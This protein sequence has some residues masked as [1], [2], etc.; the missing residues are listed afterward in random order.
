MPET[1]RMATFE[2]LSTAPPATTTTPPAPAKP[3]KKKVPK[4]EIPTFKKF[5]DLTT[6]HL[7]QLESEIEKLNQQIESLNGEEGVL[8][9][10]KWGGGEAGDEAVQN[11]KAELIAWVG[12]RLQ[13]Y[14]Q[15]LAAYK[16]LPSHASKAEQDHVAL[17]PPSKWTA[18]VA[19]LKPDFSDVFPTDDNGELTDQSKFYIMAGGVLIIFMYLG[20][21]K[22]AAINIA[23]LLAYWGTDGAIW[24]HGKG[25]GK[26]MSFGAS[27]APRKSHSRR[28]SRDSRESRDHEDEEEQGEERESFKL[29]KAMEKALKRKLKKRFSM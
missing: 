9:A 28:S 3:S 15:S 27:S 8:L 10:K 26:T 21:Q 18:T 5:T 17:A 16:S 12:T 19:A 6:L 11:K 22:L 1:P 7:R 20:C 4:K 13:L 23:L 25:K 2:P 29:D 14:H 24:G